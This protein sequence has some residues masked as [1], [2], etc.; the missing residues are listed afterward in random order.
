MAICLSAGASPAADL[1]ALLEKA[2]ECTRRSSQYDEGIELAER[3]LFDAKATVAQRAGAFQ[4]AA[5]VHDRRRKYTEIVALADRVLKDLRQDLALGTEV[6]LAASKALWSRR[7]HGEAVA[8]LEAFLPAVADQP[9]AGPVRAALG[10][11]LMDDGK[12]EQAYAALQ[13]ALDTPLADEAAAAQVLRYL[14]DVG[15][16]LQDADKCLG[17]Y[18]TLLTDRYFQRL[19]SYEQPGVRDR[20]G[21]A[22]VVFGKHDEAVAFFREA[23]TAETDTRR[24]QRYALRIGQ[25]LSDRKQYQEAL[26]ALEEVFTAYGDI[27]DY[28]FDA[29]ARIVDILRATG[30]YPAALKAARILLD[31]AADQ[32]RLGQ[33]VEQVAACLKAVDKDLGR[34]NAFI[35]FQKYGPAG[36]DGKS[37]TQDDLANPL[38]DGDYAASARRQKAFAR[39]REEAGDDAR[40]ALFRAKTF[41][42]SGKPR[43]AY[44]FFLDAFARSEVRDL[45]QM[46]K[47]L[48]VIGVR[49]VQGH[50]HGLA[51]FYDFLNHGPPGPDGKPATADDLA[52]PFAELVGKDAKGG[53]GSRGDLAGHSREDLAALREARALLRRLAVNELESSEVRIDA[54]GALVRVN[55]ARNDWA[56]QDPPA[57][58]VEQAGTNLRSGR[59][60]AAWIDAGQLAAK[61]GR[62][63]LGEVR[64]YWRRVDA[65]GVDFGDSRRRDIDRVRREFDRQCSALA[66]PRSLVPRTLKR[67]AVQPVKMDPSRLRLPK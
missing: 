12:N 23:R 66:P 29:Q 30:D 19:P 9:A 10:R 40:A 28:S 33:A 24:S 4:V 14:A 44:P 8:R 16:R 13:A 1:D 50:P 3:V 32:N 63:H 42:Y 38:A 39:L 41:I 15:Q 57:W 25:V 55:L 11:Y 61:A 46:G 52:D 62:L 65:A 27:G 45:S 35:S 20:Y 59:H 22:L 51:R 21:E 64:A 47:E 2:Q 17:A 37:G 5:T 54:L 56:G 26:P 53:A 43:E 7:Q 49:A 67:W 34:A 18:R 48:V 31:A 58:Y 6:T 36:A 60:V